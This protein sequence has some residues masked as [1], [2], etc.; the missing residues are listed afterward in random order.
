MT[1]LDTVLKKSG[2]RHFG[3]IVLNAHRIGDIQIVETLASDRADGNNFYCFVNETNTHLYAHTLDY[4]VV[5]ALGYK[6]EGRNSQAA[7]YFAAMVGMK[8]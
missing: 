8:E 6:Y 2:N 3:E 7:R 5:V 1:D 4:A